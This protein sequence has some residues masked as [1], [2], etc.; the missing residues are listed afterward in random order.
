L[1]RQQTLQAT[2]DWSWAL[3]GEA[4]RSLLRRLS[5]FANGWTLE[6]A[7]VVCGVGDLPSG[8]V[9][10]LLAE[11]TAKSLVQVVEHL[12]QS[13]YSLLETVQQ[14][15]REQLLTVGEEKDLRDRHLHW[16]LAQAEAAAPDLMGLGQ[17][18]WLA[19]LDREHDN[20]RAALAWARESDAGEQALRL[21]GALWRFW[22]V[23][24]YHAEGRRWL[25]AALANAGTVP[26]AV[27]ATALNGAGNLAWQ[28]GDYA[29]AT[30]LHEEALAL[31]RTLG[32]TRGI[33]G[34]LGNLGTVAYRQGDYR[35]AAALYEEALVRHRQLEDRWGIAAD[36]N[37]LAMVAYQRG[38]YARAAALYEEGLSLQHELQD[39]KGVA[40]SL[41][42]LGLV[43]S[44]QGDH[45]RAVALQEEALA[46]QRAL[47]DK[48]GAALTLGHL[49]TVVSQQGDYRRAA[50][51]HQESL[52]LL[53]EV[54]DLHSIALSLSNL[55]EVANLEGD[56][57]RATTLYA[58]GLTLQRRLGDKHGSA[59]SLT[60]LGMAA[61]LEGD[62]E[63]A[64]TLYGEGLL[65]S[66][67]IGARD[68]QAEGLEGLTWLAAAASRTPQ[69]ARLGGAAQALR[70]ALGVP[71]QLGRQAGHD[72]SVRTM[73][74]D[75][76]ERA[77]SS[78]WAEG[79]AMPLDE[80]VALAQRLLGNSDP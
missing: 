73:R 80:V 19:R 64:A 7:E 12:G 77:F 42:N 52:A 78:A 23:R 40:G 63:R 75:L 32:D 74:A 72:Q 34:S 28:Q 36:L 58:E 62:Y 16:G 8:E 14:Y 22:A 60:N 48:W 43:V 13:R 41:G 39:R 20:L 45:G 6:A 31:R 38:D 11:L 33:A 70:E 18:T 3:L 9:L 55:G 51:L 44:R 24:G 76:G 30:V 5:V 67:E 29:R 61:Y 15:A 69:A 66:Q 49:G 26:T 53:R 59:R 56:Y 46:L 71:L 47:G 21:A 25:E 10:D 2:L 35:R 17:V 54:G 4:E 50:A 79:Q 37:N 1:P 68:Q 65:L 57:Q 27:H